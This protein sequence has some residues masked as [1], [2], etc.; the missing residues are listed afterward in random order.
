MR[1]FPFLGATL[2]LVLAVAVA[3]PISLSLSKDLVEHP[4]GFSGLRRVL[5]TDIPLQSIHVAYSINITLGTPGQF[6]R[7]LLVRV[8]RS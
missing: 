4:T 6:F 5:T 2:C 8:V 7:V 3:A 1:V